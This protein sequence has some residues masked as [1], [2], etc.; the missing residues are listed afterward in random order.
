MNKMKRFLVTVVIT[1]GLTQMTHAAPYSDVGGLRTAD[2]CDISLVT[3][4]SN[5][6]AIPMTNG[7]I[8]VE[9]QNYAGASNITL[10]VS[11]S[12]TATSS[13]AATSETGFTNLVSGQKLAYD[14]AATIVPGFTV[15]AVN[16]GSTNT[17]PVLTNTLKVI[18][19]VAVPGN[20]P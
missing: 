13:A 12:V 2:R 11:S 5:A 1:L 3:I 9:F 18:K 4:T 19:W 7:T 6:V 15:Y 10:G 16:P 8:K 14:G 17:S 20:Q